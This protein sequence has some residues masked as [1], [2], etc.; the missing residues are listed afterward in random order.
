MFD[1]YL[2]LESFCGVDIYGFFV[3]NYFNLLCIIVL[4]QIMEINYKS[5]QNLKYINNKKV[6]S[7]I[8]SIYV[9]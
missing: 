3:K 4:V 2:F 7:Y 9:I 1:N 8:L 6:L 5:K